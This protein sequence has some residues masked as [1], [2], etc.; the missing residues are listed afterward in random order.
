VLYSLPGLS[1][2]S[3]NAQAATAVAG[4]AG[5][6]C[7]DLSTATVHQLTISQQSNTGSRV[8]ASQV[9]GKRYCQVCAAVSNCQKRN[10]SS[11]EYFSLKNILTT[12]WWSLSA[13]KLLY[14]VIRSRPLPD[15]IY[16]SLKSFLCWENFEKNHVKAEPVWSTPQNLMRPSPKCAAKQD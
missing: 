8:P 13:F 1:A 15:H 9:T 6:W 11:F 7:A 2:C 16:F 10:Y 5:S 4:C 12:I 14:V 3:I